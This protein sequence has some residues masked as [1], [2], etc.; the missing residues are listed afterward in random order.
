MKINR[1]KVIWF[2]D[3]CDVIGIFVKYRGFPFQIQHV[4]LKYQGIQRERNI[5]YIIF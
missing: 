2:Y 5:Y 3:L 4:I 1:R